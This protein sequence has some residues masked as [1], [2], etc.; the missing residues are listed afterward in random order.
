[1]AN[2]RKDLQDFGPY[3]HDKSVFE[4]PMIANKNGRVVTTTYNSLVDDRLPVRA[5]GT[6]SKDRLKV[7][8][9]ETLFFNTF[10]YGLETDVWDTGITGTASAT[11]SANTSSVVLSVGGTSGDK[12]IRQTR[13]VQ[14]YVPGR[15][16]TVAFSILLNNPVEGIRKRFGMFNPDGDGFYF[17]DSGVW[18]DGIPQYNCTISN[19]SSGEI[20][21]PRSQW[22]GDKLDGTGVS[23]ITADAS[24]IQLVVLEYEW[25]GAGEVRFGFT[26]DGVTHIVHTHQNANR[27]AGPWAQTPFLPIRMELEAISTV[28]GGP[29][30][31]LQGSNSL[32]SEGTESKVGIAQN[33]SAPFYGT[34]MAAALTSA[35]TSNNWYPVLSIR[36]KPTTLQGIVLPTTYQVATVDNTNIFFK[37]VRNAVIPA[38]VTVG[39]S[40]PQPWLDMP[41]ANSFAQYQTYIT[42]ANITVANHGTSID[43]GFVVAGGGG[44]SIILD[45]DT[46]YQ[47]GRTNLG[48]TSD[49]LTILC[50]SNNT[51]KDALAAMT[52]IEQR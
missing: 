15:T 29:F 45:K 2:F 13:N 20:T 26:I 27:Y 39:T 41:D 49:V 51:G 5:A 38:E 48:T 1:M 4:V 7:S 19:G 31:M 14:R 43:S 21:T 47:I 32:T 50:A 17:E 37:F 25:Y 18:V 23:G 22:N 8:P 36:L 40:G 9:Y 35:A 34:R 30:T 3:G 6:T 16:S 33:I 52:W 42:P 12:V 24:K 46:V 11:H 44:K 10:Q 28:A